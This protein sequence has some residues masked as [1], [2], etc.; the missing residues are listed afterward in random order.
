M[1]WIFMTQTTIKRGREAGRGGEIKENER[2]KKGIIKK[3]QK[4]IT[5]KERKW[6]KDEEDA[7]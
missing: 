7:A 1:I 3:W 5:S 2:V 6:R 4:I